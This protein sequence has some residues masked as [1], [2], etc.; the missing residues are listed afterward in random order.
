MSEEAATS[1]PPIANEAAEQK[2]GAM[3]VD[4]AAPAPAEEKPSGDDA[5]Q[6]T[7]ESESRQL[8]PSNLVTDSQ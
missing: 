8:F 3:V 2:D 5:G 4:Q 1:N 7:G 6:A